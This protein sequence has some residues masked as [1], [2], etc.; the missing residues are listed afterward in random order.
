MSS[1]MRAMISRA[2]RSQRGE[3][4]V[5]IAAPHPPLRGTFSQGR[6]LSVSKLRGTLSR[7]EKGVD[8]PEPSPLGRGW[9]GVPGE[10]SRRRLLALLRNQLQRSPLQRAQITRP[11]APRREFLEIPLAQDLGD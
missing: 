8:Q 4:K 2:P 11:W 7:R 9:R 3:A 5:V 10:G 1:A 6:R